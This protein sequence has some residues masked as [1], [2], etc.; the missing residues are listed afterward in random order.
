MRIV[1]IILAHHLPEQLVRLVRKLNTETAIFL[2]HIDKKTDNETHKKMVDPL[3]D[4]TNVHFLKRIT[5]HWG[6]FE[7][8]HATF[9]GFEMI[10]TLNLDYDYVA[11]LTGQD[12]PI[13]SNQQIEQ[14][15]QDSG[16]RS[17]IEFFPLPNPRWADENGGVERINYW[18]FRAFG[19]NLVFLKRDHFIH[20]VSSHLY[21]A[22]NAVFPLQRNP[23]EGYELYGGSAY[24]CLTR[25]CVEYIQKFIE[26]QKTFVKF[27]KHVLIPDEVIFQIILLNSPLKEQLVNDNLRYITWSSAANPYILLKKDFKD[28]I[29]SPK[30]F[31]RKF[32]S[33]IDADVLDLIDQ[34]TS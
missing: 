20:P 18:H 30:L 32:D 6:G 14:V 13:K 27:F 5:V 33:T 16:R 15:L 22:L 12:Y 34:A 19:R 2:I 26:E 17:F 4:Y 24:W 23:P 29:T 31:A 9:L 7:H 1:Y 3:K 10:Q 8:V 28:I 11:L 21:S 25:E